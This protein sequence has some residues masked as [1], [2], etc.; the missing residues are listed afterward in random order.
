[1]PD[2]LTDSELIAAFLASAEGRSQ[3]E[4]ANLAPG[5]RQSDVSRW[6][7][8][9]WKRLTDKKRHALT[10]YLR[11]GSA[12][13]YNHEAALEWFRDLE[14]VTRN[15]EGTAPK[16]EAKQFKQD[17]LELIRVM[18]LNLVGEPVPDWWYML[19]G[20]VDEGEI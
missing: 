1:M 2:R 14:Q 7:R 20:K 8:G 10:A 9:E 13:F 19:R 18:H 11:N 16:G 12:E 5:V 4:A 3:Q 6:R 15:L 17:Q